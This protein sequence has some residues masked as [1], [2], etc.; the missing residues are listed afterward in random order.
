MTQLD[1]ID[2]EILKILQ[3][4][5]RVTNRELAE[6]IGLSA[7][8][9]WHRVKRLEQ[10]G[11]IDHYACV[12]SASK[13]GRQMKAIVGVTLVTRSTQ[14]RETFEAA[15]AEIEEVQYCFWVAGDCDY[16]L[17]VTAT[18][19]Q[20]FE[21]FLDTRLLTLASVAN[22]KS[23]MALKTVK[24]TTTM[25]LDGLG[26]EIENDQDAETPQLLVQA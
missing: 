26:I 4:E 18:D 14:A 2:L 10:A 23:Q 20:G 22:V 12:L 21:N 19:L 17:L 24:E 7:A 6:R 9:C 8:P 3:R 16:Q 25:P 13:I 15:I 11:I 5:G 1:K